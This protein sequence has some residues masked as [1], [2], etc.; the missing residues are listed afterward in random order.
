MGDAIDLVYAGVMVCL[1]CVV[2]GGDIHI[3]LGLF[4]YLG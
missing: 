4:V 2:H 1:Y 3:A